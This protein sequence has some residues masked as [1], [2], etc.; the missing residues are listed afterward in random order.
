MSTAVREVQG[1]KVPAAGTY[2]IDKA[3]TTVEF[4]ARHLMI[5][6]V[7]GRF[8]DFEGVVQIAEVPE[9]STAEVTIQ[10]ASIDTGDKGRD[11]HLRSGDFF[12]LEQYPTLSYRS[13]GVEKAKGD[14]WK[15]HG[16]LTVR[17]VTRPVTLDLEFNGTQTDP[18]GGERIAFTAT[19]ELDREDFGL[20]WN[21][22]LET[23]GVL[24]GRKVKVEL[25][26]Q[27]VRQG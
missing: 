10:A 5:T 18:W 23:G 14:S 19:T 1:T 21:Q 12:D 22:A 6:K 24:V 8:T 16:E 17:G 25:D 15:L 3:H 27:A 4:V 7:R 13:T 26:V 20:T 11:E 2:A 9:E